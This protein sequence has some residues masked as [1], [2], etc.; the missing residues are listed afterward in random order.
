[1][2]RRPAPLIAAPR[3][4]RWPRRL[5][6]LLIL[7]LGLWGFG[8]VGFVARI[9]REAPGDP[10]RT[11]AVVV[12]TGG[13]ERLEAGLFL[14]ASGVA[15]KL[16]VS[17]VNETVDL[18]ALIS[19]LPPE[20]APDPALRACCIQLGYSATDTRSNADETAHW[21][22]D[23]GFQSIRLVT[24][25]YH[26]A[27]SL[28]EFRRAMP[29][30]TIESYPV[31]PNGVVEEGWWRWPGSAGLIMREYNKYLVALLRGLIL[32]DVVLTQPGATPTAP[33]DGS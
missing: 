27:R 17:G 6:L 9:P 23:Q 25:D 7:L 1:M 29:T 19:S 13:A 21:M 15:A 5:I 20:Y 18:E 14:L 10:G 11:D 30:V 12:L 2:A 8:L 3:P 16:F 26:M 31:F 28:L 4:A 22:A 24:A 33:D 32:P